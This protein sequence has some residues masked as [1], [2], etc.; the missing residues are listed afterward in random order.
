MP[1]PA[2]PRPRDTLGRAPPRPV[3]ASRVAPATPHRRTGHAACTGRVVL[4]S[5]PRPRRHDAPASPPR[6]RDAPGRRL[7]LGAAW[8][9]PPRCRLA[10]GTARRVVLHPLAPRP[11][12]V[13]QNGAGGA[14]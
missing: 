14:F 5:P 2:P 12:P 11:P 3:R 9:T 13:Q 4:P 10:P 6:P 1:W 7:A 8:H